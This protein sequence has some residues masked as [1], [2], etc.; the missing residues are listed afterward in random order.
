MTVTFVT[1]ETV[2]WKDEPQTTGKDDSL[3]VP[4]ISDKEAPMSHNKELVLTVLKMCPSIRNHFK[5]ELGLS[6]TDLKNRP[7]ETFNPS[8]PGFEDLFSGRFRDMY[9]EAEE[10]WFTVDRLEEGPTC[11]N[12]I[13]DMIK[14]AFKTTLMEEAFPDCWIPLLGGDFEKRRQWFAQAMKPLMDG[15]T[16]PHQWLRTLFADAIAF[17]NWAQKQSC[18]I[19]SDGP[20]EMY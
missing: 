9:Q 8:M 15:D 2:A 5:A 3:S 18:W 19:E 13:N 20:Y 12:E 17:L 14:A 4:I 6:Y 10:L 7:P 16:I 11:L 1:T